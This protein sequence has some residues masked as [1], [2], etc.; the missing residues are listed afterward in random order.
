VL[1]LSAC[2]EED[3]DDA[4]DVDAGARSDTSILLL[5]ALVEATLSLG[6]QSISVRS[7]SPPDMLTRTN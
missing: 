4:L 7:R 1:L 5:R 3:A 6:S 2:W